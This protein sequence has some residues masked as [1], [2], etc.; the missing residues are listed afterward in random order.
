MP[1]HVSQY[2]LDFTEE[3]KK[4]STSL[5]QKRLLELG[6]KIC[7][8]LFFEYKAFSIKYKWG[9]PDLLLDAISLCDKAVKGD[10]NFIKIK[11]QIPKIDSATPDM[12][13]YNSDVIA[14][15]ALNA[16]VS[17]SELLEFVIDKDPKHIMDITTLYT[18]TADFKAQ[19]ER[20]L[21][22]DEIDLHPVMIKARQFLLTETK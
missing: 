10:L 17:V 8:E 19:E 6:L 22:K 21:T 20:V 14:S 13:D 11:S 15:Y 9:D 5:S 3:I 7:K 12:D 4:R 2:N 1:L 16:A 18:D